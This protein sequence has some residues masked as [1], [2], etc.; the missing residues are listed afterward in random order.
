MRSEFFWVTTV[1]YMPKGQM[2]SQNLAWLKLVMHHPSKLRMIL[3]KRN[4]EQARFEV[5]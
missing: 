5:K 4:K 2:P 1:R 3:S